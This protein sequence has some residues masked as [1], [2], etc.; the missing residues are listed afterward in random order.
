MER[1]P[2]NVEDV[3]YTFANAA[4]FGLPLAETLLALKADDEARVVLVRLV[5]ENVYGA[6]IILGNLLDERGDHLGAINAY[7][8][9]ADQGDGFSAFNLGLLHHE[10]GDTD[11]AS[12]A[13][14]RARQMGDLAESPDGYVGG[15]EISRDTS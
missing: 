12:E 10:L 8:R 7:R 14:R 13:F 15:H 11:S 5:E 3:T 6:A 2:R 1:D 4:A 9:G